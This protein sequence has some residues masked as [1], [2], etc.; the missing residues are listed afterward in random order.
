MAK[1]CRCACKARCELAHR[2]SSG[3]LALV[4]LG[5]PDTEEGGQLKR[6]L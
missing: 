6:A 2:A 5:C 3:G 1:Y 4:V